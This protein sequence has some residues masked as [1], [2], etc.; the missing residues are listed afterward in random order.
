MRP[1]EIHA[2]I[3][4]LNEM[5][6]PTTDDKTQRAARR[7][8]RA[9]TRCG[10][11]A[12]LYKAVLHPSQSGTG[13]VYPAWVVESVLQATAAQFDIARRARNER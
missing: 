8:E 6:W 3:I 2:E 4:K 5:P 10:L 1:D 11:W 9:A 7:Y 12:D 13:E